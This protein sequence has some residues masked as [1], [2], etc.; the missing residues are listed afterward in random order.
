MYVLLNKILT[1]KLFP[2]I[3]AIRALW[4]S[5]TLPN[6]R[7][8]ASICT[9]EVSR[10]AG[11]FNLAVFFISSIRAVIFSVTDPRLRHTSSIGTL[12][13]RNTA[14]LDTALGRFCWIQ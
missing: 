4:L 7:Y 3:Q 5:I 2:L 14:L 12:K 1:A 13:F 8:T 11:G 6:D 10:S 9:S